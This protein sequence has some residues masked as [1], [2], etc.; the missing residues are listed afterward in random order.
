MKNWERP[1]MMKEIFGIKKNKLMLHKP[2]KLM[3]P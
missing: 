1:M 3:N 2:E